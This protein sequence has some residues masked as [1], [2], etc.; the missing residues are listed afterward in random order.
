LNS[1]RSSSD[2][3]TAATVPASALL[4]QRSKLAKKAESLHLNLEAMINRYGT[5][6]VV[7]CTLT[8]AENLRCAKKAQERFKSINTHLL[9]ELFV[10]HVTAFHRG[11]KRGRP[12]YHLIA[13]TR[14]DVRTGFDFDAWRAL[15]AH[16]HLFGRHNARY[17]QLCA[18]VFASA[19]PALKAI[20]KT[21]RDRAAGYGFGMVETYPVRSNAEA[22]G[23]YVGSY[24]RVGA[25]NRQWRDKGMRTIRYSL[26]AGE[27]IASAR[28]SWVYGPGRAW[29][30]GCAA[31]ALITGIDQNGLDG[32]AK[33]WGSKWARQLRFEIGTL[34]RWADKMGEGF[35]RQVDQFSTLSTADRIEAAMQLV[36]HFRELETQQQ[37]A[38]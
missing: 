22:V 18:P 32:F 37:A 23:R 17:R 12:H 14:E 16:V 28:F 7:L 5:N 10:A 33:Q 29:R 27:R 4:G 11:S 34:G 26:P 21:F 15:L 8:F 24:V 35:Y 25:E 13:V 2:A 9:N 19:N 1:S 31:W 30:Q 36:R 38:E 20:W 6:R 3:L